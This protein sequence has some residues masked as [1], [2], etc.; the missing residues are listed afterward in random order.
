MIAYLNTITGELSETP[1]GSPMT[2]LT[3]AKC[4]EDW[5]LEVIPDR[6]IAAT[7]TGFFSAKSAYGGLLLVHGQWSAPTEAGRGWMFSLSLRGT[8]L[9]VASAATTGKLPL[10]AEGTFTIDGKTRKS[11]TITL[12]VERAVFTG[13]ED[14]PV[15]TA[16]SVRIGVTGHHEYQLGGQWWRWAPVINEENKPE[17]VWIGPIL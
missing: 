12:E 10:F 7:A 3:G 5:D 2:K 16:A 4:G 14:T 8:D 17:F 1:G 9:A 15:E 13:T 11:Q 6:E